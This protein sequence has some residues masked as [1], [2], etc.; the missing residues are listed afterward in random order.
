MT[1]EPFLLHTLPDRTARPDL[2]PE[3]LRPPPEGID[4]LVAFMETFR[5]NNA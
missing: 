4:K 3:L 5:K 2:N 1:A